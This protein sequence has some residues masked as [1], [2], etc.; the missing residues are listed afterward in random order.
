MSNRWLWLVVLVVAA[1][2][3]PAQTAD[4]LPSKPARYVSDRAL[5]LD[6]AQ[7]S[8]LNTKLETFERE[9]SN[10]VVVALFGKLPE[11]AEIAQYSTQVF[12]HWKVGQASKDNGVVLFIFK[13]DR[14][15]FIQPGRGLEGA[16]PDVTCDA[17]IRNEI[18]PHFRAEDFAGGVEAGVTAILA[19]TQGEYKGTGKTVADQDAGSEE[20]GGFSFFLLLVVLAFLFMSPRRGGMVMNRRGYRSSPAWGLRGGGWGGGGG[21]GGGGGGGGGGGFSGGG[22]SSSGGGAGG[23]W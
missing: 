17:I 16:L 23:S 12:R 4:S 19:A 1:L 21:F 3:A 9:T 22:G 18:V 6:E 10:Q 7:I 11:D 14:K 2:G 8:Q 20:S 5:V 13:E 15:V